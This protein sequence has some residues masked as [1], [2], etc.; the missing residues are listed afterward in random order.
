MRRDKSVPAFSESVMEALLRS[1]MVL[2]GMLA[3]LTVLPANAQNYPERPITL[4]VPFV[5][6]GGA[7]AVGRVIANG[8]SA[9]LNQTIVVENVGGA[10][11][12]LGAARGAR[13]QPDGYTLTLTHLGQAASAT[14]YR[15]LP[16]DPIGDFE[17]IG[18]TAVV[19]MVVIGPKSSSAKDIVELVAQIRSKKTGMT[20]ANGG[21]GSGSHFCGMLFMSA[22]KAQMQVVPYK[23]AA[24]AMNDVLGGRIDVFCDQVTTAGAQA[25]AGSVKAFAVSTKERLPGM[26]DLPTL[27]ET[28]LPGF[29]LGIWIGLAAPKGTPQPIIEK[30]ASAMKAALATP[31]VAKRLE[32]FGTQPPAKELLEPARFKK[33]FQ[34]EADKWRP[35]ITESG[36]YAD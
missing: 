22:L 6:G 28:V 7:D 24:P 4:I 11:G 34:E 10:G 1:R 35:I 9:Q 15:K 31:E 21:I 29:E 36:T 30:L 26:P 14:L 8:M 2:A 20:I 32:E 3:V 18:I 12:T 17:P 23:S 19:P 16:F 5:A 33:Y 25:K 27:N 13:A